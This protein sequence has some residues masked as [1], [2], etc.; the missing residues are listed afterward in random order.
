MKILKKMTEYIFHVL[1]I[2]VLF[3]E[4]LSH[5]PPDPMIR[6]EIKKSDT[7]SMYSLIGAESSRDYSLEYIKIYPGLYSIEQTTHQYKIKRAT[8][9]YD[10]YKQEVELKGSQLEQ[11]MA[12]IVSREFLQHKFGGEGFHFSFLSDNNRFKFGFLFEDENIEKNEPQFEC[13]AVAMISSD[14]GQVIKEN[15]P[16]KIGEKA[17][18]ISQIPFWAVIVVL[19]YI[20]FLNILKN[21]KKRPPTFGE[22]ERNGI[23][24][25]PFGN[26][27]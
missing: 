24:N 6:L 15:L 12:Y 20:G 3:F 7:P 25:P 8:F 5:F 2:I 16:C 19:W 27:N 18:L 9:Q 21:L 11:P 1:T 4:V 22:S 23:K 10:H 17:S 13:Q 26:K 14:S